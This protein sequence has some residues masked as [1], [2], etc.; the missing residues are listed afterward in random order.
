MPYTVSL[1]YADNRQYDL[2][3]HSILFGDLNVQMQL[4]ED[5]G[6]VAGYPTPDDSGVSNDDDIVYMPNDGLKP[7]TTW[8]ELTTKPVYIPPGPD[9]RPENPYNPPNSENPGYQSGTP[10]W[11]QE[12]SENLAPALNI[13]FNKLFPFCMI[14]DLKMFWDKLKGIVGSNPDGGL[15]AQAR[16]QYELVTIPGIPFPGLQ[17]GITFDLQPVAT[18]LHYV[19]PAVFWFL[20]VCVV[21]SVVHFWRSILTGA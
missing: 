10:E 20:I 21:M 3:N 14:Y 2:L 12:T 8:E 16:N 1:W 13:E 7:G 15:S 11:K 18:V 9:E 17:Q 4:P 19:R 6:M 5:V